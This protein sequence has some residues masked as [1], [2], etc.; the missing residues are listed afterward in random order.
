MKSPASERP[1]QPERLGKRPFIQVVELA[2]DRHAM[3]ELAHPDRIALEPGC[4]MVGSRLPFER[5]GKREHHLGDAVE[6][7]EERRDREILGADAV[8][9][10]EQP[11]KHMKAA[12][13][14]ARA[15]ERPQVGN[16][17]HDAQERRVALRVGADAAG[18]RHVEVAADGAAGE[19][20]IHPGQRLDKGGEEPFAVLQK[21]EQRAARRPRPEARQARKQRLGHLKRIGSRLRGLG[22]HC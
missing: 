1:A 4:D 14:E 9:R 3:G 7:G 2:A 19:R 13:E 15:L 6:P 20:R 10:G 11:A 21:V 5:G 8:E 16:V 17:G 18:G 12:G 22:S